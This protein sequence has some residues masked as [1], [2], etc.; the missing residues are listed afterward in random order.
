VTLVTASPSDLRSTA[1]T[2]TTGAK[3]IVCRRAEAGTRGC[4]CGR[5]PAGEPELVGRVFSALA[6]VAA[7]HILVVIGP[8]A[9]MGARIGVIP[10][11]QQEDRNSA[12][13]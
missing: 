9:A 3:V 10:L 4:A 1:I 5:H 12:P 6:G 11:V 7:K 8:P 2:D 13:V